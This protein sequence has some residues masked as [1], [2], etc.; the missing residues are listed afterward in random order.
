MK[1]FRVML[2]LVTLV[3]FVPACGIAQQPVTLDQISGFMELA[4]QSWQGVKDYTCIFYKREL[5]KGHLL[6]K[7]TIQVKFRKMPYSVYMKW[8]TYPHKGRELLF[9]AGKN[10]DK[11]KVHEGGVIGNININLNPYGEKA[12]KDN[13]HTVCEATIGSTIKLLKDDLELAKAKNDGTFADLGIKS[14]EG[15]TAR[16]FRA[17]FPEASVKPVSTHLA[18]K[19]K[20]YSADITVCIDSTGLPVVVE[21]RSASGKI[22]EY[23]VYKNIKINPGLTDMDFSQD[24]KEYRY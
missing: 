10:N 4:W 18:V 12:L 22:I 5:V 11:I 19:G 24:N 13:R 20:Y 9:V 17:V 14:Y 21:N 1:H 16:C 2:V 7:E 15:V 23:Y 3:L 6:N 8:I